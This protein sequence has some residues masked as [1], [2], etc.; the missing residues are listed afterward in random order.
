[1]HVLTRSSMIEV[2]EYFNKMNEDN[3]M[4]AFKGGIT[5]DL[6]A[7]LL[8]IAENKLDRV[9]D[10]PKVKK[11]VFNILVECFQNVYHHFDQPFE[12]ESV[13]NSAILMVGKEEDFFV[14]MTG[15]FIENSKVNP[16][17][18]KMD[19]INSLDKDQLKNVY[20]EVLNNEQISDKGGAG[21][22][23]IDIVRRSGQKIVYDFQ[24]VN[25][26]YSYF[27]LQIRVS[28]N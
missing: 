2:Y 11:K 3:V 12:A 7:S 6:L 1:M 17:K 28:V 16:L 24:N 23:M 13:S 25:E 15:N 20:R 18:E 10:K 8:Q 26:E 9:T 4:L 27:S 19:F 5:S 22:G 14:I 21:L